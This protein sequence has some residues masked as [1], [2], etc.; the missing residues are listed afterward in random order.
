[1]RMISVGQP[2]RAVPLTGSLCLAVATRIDGSIPQR[3]ARPPTSEADDI[4]IANPS[5][6]TVVAAKVTRNGSGWTA[7]HA[8]VYRTA[9]R[10]FEGTVYYRA[11]RQ[12]G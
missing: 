12:A 8:V 4:R 6:L 1:V 3:L 11:P 2:P 9:R 5:G 7:D 10:L